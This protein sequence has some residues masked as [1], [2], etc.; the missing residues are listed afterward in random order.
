LT[1][2]SEPQLIY[3]QNSIRLRRQRLFGSVCCEE[4]ITNE[5]CNQ[6]NASVEPGWD[7][8]L[9]SQVG[10]C[11]HRHIELNNVSNASVESSW[12]VGVAPLK[13]TIKIHKWLQLKELSVNFGF[14]I[15]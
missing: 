14:R 4:I 15:G 1:E 7:V 13:K 9:L 8:G 6:S 10:M 3:K 11:G 12:D 2:P 5:L